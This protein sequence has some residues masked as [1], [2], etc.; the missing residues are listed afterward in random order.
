MP[1]IRQLADQYAKA[2]L[3]R[4]IDVR[5]AYQ[6]FKTN[7]E[8]GKAMDVCC[9]SVGNYKKEPDKMQVKILRRMVQVLQPDPGILLKF[10]GY[11]SKDIK[12]FA[13]RQLETNS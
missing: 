5:C 2:D 1:R 12:A 8:L 10:L 4:E 13:K 11:S 7:E 6:G 3:Q 9:S